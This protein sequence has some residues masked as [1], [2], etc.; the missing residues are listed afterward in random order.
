MELRRSPGEIQKII[1]A[2]ILY[3]YIQSVNN[4]HKEA[5]IDPTDMQHYD[6]ST[7]SLKFTLKEKEIHELLKEFLQRLVDEN[8]YDA[9]VILPRQTYAEIFNFLEDKPCDLD[10]VIEHL[11]TILIN[12]K[13][14]NKVQWKLI[15]KEYFKIDITQVNVMSK[16]NLA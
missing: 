1:F 6:Q 16:N 10:V 2:A 3:S 15:F 5:F 8:N 9:E 11:N 13:K 7:K 12:F 14:H 4:S